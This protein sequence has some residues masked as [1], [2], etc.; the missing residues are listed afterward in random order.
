MGYALPG[1]GRGQEIRRWGGAG[2]GKERR[3]VL[4]KQALV[5]KVQSGARELALER[6]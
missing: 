4:G 3:W 2:M 1:E 5:K 6:A